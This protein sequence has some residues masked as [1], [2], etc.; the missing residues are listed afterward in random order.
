MATEHEDFAKLIAAEISERIATDIRAGRWTPP[1][2]WLT[3]E[4]A[5]AYLGG[6]ILPG[7]LETMRKEGR[8]PRYSRPSHK[9]VR[10]RRADLDAWLEENAVEPERKG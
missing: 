1:A 2:E 7:G 4:Q 10:Y 3:P 6:N 5:C 8:G 9:M